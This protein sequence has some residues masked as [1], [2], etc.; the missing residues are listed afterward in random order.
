[1][2]RN[3]WV[4]FWKSLGPWARFF[5]KGLFIILALMVDLQG[6]WSMGVGIFTPPKELANIRCFS[7]FPAFPVGYVIVWWYWP[8]SPANQTKWQVFRMKW[9]IHVFRIFSI[10]AR[11]N[12]FGQL[13]LPE[14]IYHYLRLTSKHLLTRFFFH[15]PNMPKTPNLRRFLD[16]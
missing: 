10:L 7:G 1:M 15:P 12:S 8:G 13:G 16:V 4:S 11:D 14:Y 3:G 2:V 9:M 5:G 6:I